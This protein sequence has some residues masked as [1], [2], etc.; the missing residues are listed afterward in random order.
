MEHEIR[1]HLWVTPDFIEPAAV[2]LDQT[3]STVAVLAQR[4]ADVR[5]GFEMLPQDGREPGAPSPKP[6]KQRRHAG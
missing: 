4:I 1:D 5:K 3:A 2:T 6:T